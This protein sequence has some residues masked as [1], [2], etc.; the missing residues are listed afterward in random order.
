MN[1]FGL[2]KRRLATS[3]SYATKS[4]SV[5]TSPFSFSTKGNLLH[6]FSYTASKVKM[7]WREDWKPMLVSFWTPLR[8]KVSPLFDTVRILLT[9][10]RATILPIL[11]HIRY[12][13]GLFLTKNKTSKLTDYTKAAFYLVPTMVQKT[14]SFA[15]QTARRLSPTLRRAHKQIGLLSART[16]RTILPALA[17]FNTKIG[18]LATQTKRTLLPVS[19]PINNKIGKV[20]VQVKRV[21]LPILAPIQVKLTAMIPSRLLRDAP[22]VFGAFKRRKAAFF[23]FFGATWQLSRREAWTSNLISVTIVVFCTMVY[24]KRKEQVLQ[25][26]VKYGFS[27]KDYNVIERETQDGDAVYSMLVK[28]GLTHRQTDSLLKAIKPSF[29][30]EKLKTGKPYTTLMDK[31]KQN[32]VSYLVFEPDPKRYFIFDLAAPSVK[33]VKREVSVREVETSG[34]LEKTLYNS[35]VDNGL[36][37]K[38]VNMVQEA[39]ENKMDIKRCAEGD[40]YKLIWEEELADGQPIGV[41]KLTSIYVKGQCIPEPIYAFYYNNGMMRGWYGKKGLPVREGFLDT[42]VVNATVTSRFN[43]NRKHPILGYRRPHLGTDF[44]A[45][46]GTPIMSVADGVVEEAKYAV[47]NGRYVKIKHKAPY[48]TQ[49]LHMSRFA[50]GIERGTSV[51]QKQVIGYI[52]M[53]GLT[54]GPHVCFR[55]WK[56]GTAIDHFTER[57]FTTHDSIEFKE[58]V[59]TKMA[60]LDKMPV[61][62]KKAPHRRKTSIAQLQK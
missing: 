44:A 22:S 3:K 25:S 35:L 8:Q 48:Q 39:L 53:S 62:E 43:P 9:H 12:E 61:P 41:K 5:S 29:D 51:K 1:V 50:E 42:P 26:Q 55:L 30:F 7:S 58:L 57:F 21:L 11:W 20:T 23:S 60:Q 18:R 19:V 33:E 31:K 27:F 59:N 37:D 13:I 4:N 32:G 34:K 10:V 49:Y 54:T 45:P 46:R 56:N 24:I 40:E 47:G 16:K 36:S 17:P 52:G 14:G 6:H 28:S 2:A 38:L 15:V